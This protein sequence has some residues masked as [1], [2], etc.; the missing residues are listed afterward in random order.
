MKKEIINIIRVIGI[1]FKEIVIDIKLGDVIYN[2]IELVEMDTI[3]LHS[4]YKDIDIETN[5]KDLSSTHKGKV[6]KALKPYIYN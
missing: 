3:I 4:F 2:S 5:W 1:N 6:L